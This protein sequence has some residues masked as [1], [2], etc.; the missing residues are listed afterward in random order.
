MT[1][2]RVTIK[3]TSDGLIINIGAGSWIRLLDELKTHLNQRASF[4]KGGRVALQVGA[5]HLT[6]SQLETIGDI[7]TQH[8]MSLWAVESDSASTQSVT[9][10]LGL[11]VGLTPRQSVG[12]QTSR[13]PEGDSV[14]IQ[15]TV[16]SGQVINHP[17]NVIIIGDVNPGGE[18]KA[19]GSIIVWGHLRGVVHAGLGD[20]GDKAIV[21]AL[22]LSP[23][24]LRINRYIARPP[25]ASQVSKLVV[26]EMA[27]VENGQIV[28]ESWPN[29]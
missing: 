2:E 19:G 13:L 8:R 25:T 20:V 16:R 15:R 7:L 4:F 26:P 1:S 5:R 28:A 10:E 27:S 21:C 12:P 23:T 14:V 6:T 3:G 22:Q 18:V 9:A 17:G 11:E 24:Q 29:R